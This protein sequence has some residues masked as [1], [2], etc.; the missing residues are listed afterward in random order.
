M[1]RSP[2]RIFAASALALTGMTFAVSCK[3][4]CYDCVVT[5]NNV[6]DTINSICTDSPQ[7]TAGYL[8]SWKVICGSSGGET[9]VRDKD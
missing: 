1:L 6:K 9:I 3:P 5:S 8:E 2:K 7:Y 4:K